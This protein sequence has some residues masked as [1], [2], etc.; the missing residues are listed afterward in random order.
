MEKLIYAIWTAEDSTGSALISNVQNALE[1]AAFEN[2]TINV[3]DAAVAA[4]APLRQQNSGPLPAAFVS[5]W[6]PSAQQRTPYEAALTTTGTRIAGFVVS[7]STPL[8]AGIDAAGRAE[9]FFQMAMLQQPPRLTRA[10][11][12]HHWLDHHTQVAIDTQSTFYY[13]QNVVSRR[14]HADGPAWDAIV[15]EGFPISALADLAVFFDAVG[16]AARLQRHTTEMMRSC[17]KFID[18]DAIDVLPTSRYRVA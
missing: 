13:A 14:L 12:L 5:F 1:G 6:L 10:E 9:G 17:A 7:E 11:W 16:D 8:Q 2:L 15:E 3:S 18:F 4:G